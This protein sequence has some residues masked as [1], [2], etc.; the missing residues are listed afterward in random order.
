LFSRREDLACPSDV[1][2]NLGAQ[3]LWAIKDLLSA[4]PLNEVDFHLGPVEVSGEVQQVDLDEEAPP[5]EGGTCP[6]VGYSEMPAIEG[7]ASANGVYASGRLEIS[8]GLEIRRGESHG[9][10]ARIAVYDGSSDAMWTP[11]QLSRCSDFTAA[12]EASN[13][14]G[15]DG[16]MAVLEGFDLGD[17]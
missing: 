10:P 7:S 8:I 4:Q 1:L 5:V 17:G 11:E 2:L 16:L 13:S 6:E 14:T 3:V 9:P 15:A 12:N